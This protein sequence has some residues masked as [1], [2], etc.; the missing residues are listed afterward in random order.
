MSWRWLVPLCYMLGLFEVKYFK[1][2]REIQRK[3]ARMPHFSWRFGK[4][5]QSRDVVFTANHVKTYIC[6]QVFGS[7]EATSMLNASPWSF[8]WPCLALESRLTSYYYKPANR[9]LFREDVILSIRLTLPG[10]SSNVETCINEVWQ[11]LFLKR[12]QSNYSCHA[13]SGI[14]GVY[15]LN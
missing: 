8:P 3:L 6:R 13:A 15:Q 10:V 5:I 14:E 1:N 9:T 11:C 7:P 12:L 2:P 4:L